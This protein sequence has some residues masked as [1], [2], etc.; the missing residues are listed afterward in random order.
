MMNAIKLLTYYASYR[1]EHLKVSK[2]ENNFFLKLHYPQNE[3]NFS[4]NSALNSFIGL[5]F[6]E[7]WF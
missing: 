1:L 3:R 5:N 2:S 4:Q 6:K 7:K